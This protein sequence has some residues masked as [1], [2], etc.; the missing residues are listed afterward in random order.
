MTS[1]AFLPLKGAKKGEK[2]KAFK[3]R[4]K[5]LTEHIKVL[6]ETSAQKRAMEG[7]LPG[8]NPDDDLE[9]PIGVEEIAAGT[10]E[11]TV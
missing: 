2:Q 5:T 8:G 7:D 9:D 4:L 11:A 6:G 10:L 1:Q 3:K